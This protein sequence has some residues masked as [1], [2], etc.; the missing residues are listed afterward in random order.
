MASIVRFFVSINMEDGLGRDCGSTFY[1]NETDANAYTAAADDAARAATT[2]GVLVA[3]YAGLTLANLMGVSIGA[4]F[5]ADPPPLASSI[6][7]T[8]L[9][10]NK[11]RISTSAGGRGGDFSI[12]ARNP[13]NYTQDA[14]SLIVSITTPTAMSQFVTAYQ[15]V[16]ENAFGFVSHI[17]GAKIVD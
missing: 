10:G 11:L 6:A 17:M 3:K 9:R 7:D 8:V 15:T 5:L 14:D 12:P 1:I 16:V 13:A 4:E 2:V